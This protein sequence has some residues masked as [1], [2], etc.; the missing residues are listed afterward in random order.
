SPMDGHVLKKYVKEGQYVD[1]G[2]PLYDVV[3]LSSVWIQAQVWEEDMAFLP[4]H[5]RKERKG[6]EDR[7]RPSFLV[8]ATSRAY[9]GEKFMGRLS[10][11][12]PHVDLETRTVLARFE[13]DNPEHKLRPGTAVTVKL[14]MPPRQLPVLTSLWQKDAMCG[15]S[16]GPG[17]SFEALLRYGV[18]EE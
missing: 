15:L 11:V 6:E 17:A 13:L 5:V 18:R 16:L 14:H 3:D 4:V 1:E 7:R 8:E 10:F 12:F 9:P 2:M